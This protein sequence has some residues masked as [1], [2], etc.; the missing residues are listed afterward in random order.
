M[1]EAPLVYS[2]HP[3]K[4]MAKPE[5]EAAGLPSKG[6]RPK[7]RIE[8]A[9]RAGKDVT[10]IYE[11]TASDTQLRELGR[12]LRKKFGTGGTVKNSRIELQG[13]WVE[14]TLAEL[15]SLGYLPVKSGG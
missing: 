1:K 4:F 13:N 3:E 9:N 10:V 8:K 12:A 5:V 11:F 15:R 7:V 2:S 6:Q 14:K